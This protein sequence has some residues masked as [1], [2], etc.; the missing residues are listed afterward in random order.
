LKRVKVAREAKM[1]SRPAPAAT[2]AADDVS[3]AS[4][5]REPPPDVQNKSQAQIASTMHE[6]LNSI[7]VPLEHQFVG[8]KSAQKLSRL[9]EPKLL[10]P[11]HASYQK[12]LSKYEKIVKSPK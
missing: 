9:E 1:P 8:P 7:G 12:L 5:L 6:Y 10:S 2:S 11:D 4:T 3:A